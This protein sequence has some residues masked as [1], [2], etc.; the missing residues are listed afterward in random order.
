[1]TNNQW[2]ELIFKTFRA[3]HEYKKL[4]ERA[5]AEYVRR[6]GYHPSDIDDDQWIDLLHLGN[7]SPDIDMVIES[8]KYSKQ[9]HTGN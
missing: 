7:G 3:Q 9:L 8:A 5:E 2:Q 1:M 4:L 6:Y